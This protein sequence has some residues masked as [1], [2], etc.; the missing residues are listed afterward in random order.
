MQHAAQP[1][2]VSM[3]CG[4]NPPWVPA[5]ARLADP[6][7]PLSQ[8]DITALEFSLPKLLKLNIS[9]SVYPEEIKRIQNSDTFLLD[10]MDVL[11]G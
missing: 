2:N 6:V 4:R 8:A 5:C 10:Q 3:Y 1:G 7:Q 11:P 9:L